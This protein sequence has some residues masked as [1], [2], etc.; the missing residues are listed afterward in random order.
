MD[1]PEEMSDLNQKEPV[2]VSVGSPDLR[3]FVNTLIEDV[4][5]EGDLVIYIG[6]IK[7]SK[8]VKS[9]L[10]EQ[11]IDIN[12]VLFFDMATKISGEAPD[13]VKNT[14]FFN[15]EDINQVNMQLDDAIEAK[16]ENRDAM[17]IF[18][19]ISTLTIY[20]DEEV[21]E[22]FLQ[23]LSSKMEDWPVKSVLIGVEKEMDEEMT[24]SIHEAVENKYDLAEN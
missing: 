23:K 12:K 5:G 14:V 16:P 22:K 13:N 24:E 10:K 1:Y 9:A 18:D 6:S 19:T 17:V 7:T 8:K 15:P 2:Y 21:I 11:D 4:T 20:N 3:D